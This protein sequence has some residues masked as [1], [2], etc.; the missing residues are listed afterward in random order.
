[1]KDS[2]TEPI[3]WDDVEDWWKKLM[4]VCDRHRIELTPDGDVPWEHLAIALLL[5]HE[6]SFR[7]PKRGKVGRPR[8]WRKD[9]ALILDADRVI[10]ERRC[11]DSGAI[12]IMTT[13][14]RFARR[15]NG[16]NERTLRNRLSAA[17]KDEKLA[18]IIQKAREEARDRGFG[19]LW[20]L[21]NKEY[22]FA[23]QKR[24]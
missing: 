5:R 7:P 19:D 10:G 23:E 3:D 20:G 13:S 2:T 18:I 15:W 22:R 11:S 24:Q 6:P 1:M 17:R 12:H 21:M 16:E 14:P 9:I 8:D 4:L